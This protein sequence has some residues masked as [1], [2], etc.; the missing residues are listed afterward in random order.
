[1]Q[2]EF[3]NWS[4]SL[5]FTPDTIEK[6]RN[7]DELAAIVRRAAED[8]KI[9]RP[10]GAGHSSMPLVETKD[11]LV[12]LEHFRGITAHDE[13][14][15]D[16]TIRTG[17]TLNEAGQEFARLGLGLHN[18]GDVNV[19]AAVGAVGTG[20][21]GTGKSM[22]ILSAPHM[23]VRLVAADG[24]IREYSEEKD[25]EF[26][27]A[28][29]LSLGTLGIFTE[30]RLRLVPAF[31]VQRKEWCTHIDTCLENL[32]ELIK[33]NRNFDF[34]WYPRSD[35]AK[36][37]IINQANEGMTDVPYARLDKSMEGPGHEIIPRHREIK[38]DEMEYSVPRKAGP[39]CFREVRKRIK[40]R[41]RKYVAWR[42][43]YRTVAA[44]DIYL[45]GNYRKDTATI[46]LHH[47]AGLPYWEF[48]RD[49]EPIFR[50]Y[51]GIP[52]WAKKHSLRAEQLSSLYPEWNRFLQ[53]RK[54]MDPDGVFLN[55]FLRELLGIV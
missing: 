37:R 18:Y 12:C 20:T 47:N 17:L 34:Y 15:N 43:L 49:I 26:M 7:E 14:T 40:E 19:Q 42:V 9:V 53:I 38:F 6:P 33:N 5:R 24:S 51:S 45:S 39:E 52:H 10:V 3:R 31:K 36:L 16:V 41:H 21:H 8:K 54:Q 44:D 27:K 4:G 55:P 29:R 11:I 50:A 28:A 46:S 25:P 35:E 1:M 32:D 30:I 23:G 48:F 22:Q 13:K 2:Q